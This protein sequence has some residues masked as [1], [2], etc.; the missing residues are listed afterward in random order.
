MAIVTAT[1]VFFVGVIA[2][3]GIGIRAIPSEMIGLFIA[4]DGIGIRAIPSEMIGLFI[5]SDISARTI[6]SVV[7]LFEKWHSLK[8]METSTFAA[9]EK[10]IS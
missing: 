1:A 7:G 9:N 3:D 4:G 2:G 8:P 6:S 10:L 5:A